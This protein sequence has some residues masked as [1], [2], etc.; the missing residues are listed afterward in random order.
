VQF[1]HVGEPPFHVDRF[2]VIAEG[3]CTSCR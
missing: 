3:L 1:A 2:S